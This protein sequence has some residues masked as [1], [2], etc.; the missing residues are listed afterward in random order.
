MMKL[1][2]FLRNLARRGLLLNIL[3]A[4][5][6]TSGCSS[7]TTPT[8]TRENI[9]RSIQDICWSEYKIEVK[10]KLVEDTV[11]VY[12]PLEDLFVKNTKAEK[13]SEKFAVEQINNEF[14][15]DNLRLE[16]AIKAIPE[17][18][19]YQ[20]Y[21]YNKSALEKMDSILK[22]LRRVVFSM[23]HSRTDEPKFFSFITADIKNGFEIQEIFYYLDLK[24]VIYEF[25]SWSEYQHRTIQDTHIREEITGD[26]EGLHVDYKNITF[27]D[28]ITAQIRQRIKLKFQKPEV[29]QNADIDKEI[30]KIVVY[31]LKIYDF[32][33][34]NTV[35]LNNLV[36]N[37]KTVLN[38]AAVWARARE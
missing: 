12:L 6:L 38:Q 9:A 20:E 30:L 4:I 18:E 26:R 27:E 1:K 19:G 3:L 23:G 33:D 10:T 35:E 22:V 24:K 37:Y 15:N 29:D 34:F 17:Q 16:Y 5:Y 31:T 36:T 14:S 28:F 8:Y 11:W 7:S 21:T 2:L 13:F 25:I 32:K